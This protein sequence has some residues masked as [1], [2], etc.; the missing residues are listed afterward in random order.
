MQEDNYD[1]IVQYIISSQAKFYRLAYSYVR[2]QDDALDIV[3][4]SVCKA[5]EHYHTLRNVDY[6][7]TWFYRILV[8]E[9]LN[10]MKRR[11]RELASETIEEAAGTAVHS[12][13][14]FDYDAED[15][16]EKL[17]LLPGDVQNIIRLY[18]FE[19][20]KLKEIAEVT[21]KNISTVK[22]KLYRGLKKLKIELEGDLQ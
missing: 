16:L 4:N 15:L 3:Q 6:V 10:F 21:G 14:V 5:L 18:Y 2:N 1:K 9:S 13:S 22:A 19:E 12:E 7:K 11:R 20:F 8:N 17:E